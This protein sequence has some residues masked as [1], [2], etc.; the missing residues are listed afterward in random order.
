MWSCKHTEGK[1]IEEKHTEG[2]P[3]EEMGEFPFL[4][5]GFCRGMALDF[6]K[7][8]KETGHYLPRDGAGVI[9]VS[10]TCRTGS[11]VPL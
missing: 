11:M 6:V 9:V 4:I 3:I 5:L 1:H 10:S 8:G 7:N 2:K